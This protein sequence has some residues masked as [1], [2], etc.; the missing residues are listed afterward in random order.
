MA[1]NFT[2]EMKNECCWNLMIIMLEKCLSITYQ[3]HKKNNRILKY[4]ALSIPVQFS[5]CKSQFHHVVRC[6]RVSSLD[7]DNGVYE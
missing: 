4:F 3:N 7:K 6:V 1:L 5:V 2:I